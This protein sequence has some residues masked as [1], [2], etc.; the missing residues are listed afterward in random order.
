[1]N[2]DYIGIRMKEINKTP[3]LN[4]CVEKIVLT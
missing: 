2:G 4:K 3:V 1:M